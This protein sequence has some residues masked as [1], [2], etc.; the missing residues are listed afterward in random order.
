[1]IQD[2][3]YGINNSHLLVFANP[4]ESELI[5]GCRAGKESR[6]GGPVAKFD[7]IPSKNSFPYL[8]DQNI[9]GETA[10]TDYNGLEILGSYGPM[11][12]TQSHFVPKGYLIVAATSGPN[13]ENNTVGVRVH[14]LPEHQG[15][16]LLPGSQPGYPL[17]NSF[18]T[19]CF[20]TGVRHRSAAVAIQ[21]T[22]GTTYTKPPDSAIPV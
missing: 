20:G 17:I 10:P 14:E 19:R 9:V 12:L 2:K 13:S 16:R 7:Y 8:T 6:T 3:G 18:Y 4:Q 1:M 22:A 15:L 5:Q 11:Y 21:V